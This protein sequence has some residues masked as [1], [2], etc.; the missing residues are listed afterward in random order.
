MRQVEKL[1]GPRGAPW[2]V[3]FCDLDRSD[4]VDQRLA[5]A[6]CTRD[7]LDELRAEAEAL[8]GVTRKRRKTA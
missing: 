4:Y 6:G 8:L 2:S 7:D 5:R 3:D 1:L